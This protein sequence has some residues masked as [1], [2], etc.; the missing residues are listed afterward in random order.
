[1]ALACCLTSS[2][3]NFL[4]CEVGTITLCEAR[5]NRELA[6]CLS[7]GM[8]QSLVLTLDENKN[9]IQQLMTYHALLQVQT[10]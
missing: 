2:H 10:S 7:P 5:A 4:I 6:L 9:E 1:M 8:C 3:P